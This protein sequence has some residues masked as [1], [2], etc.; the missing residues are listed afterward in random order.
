MAKVTS[1]YQ[2]KLPKAIVQE[3]NIQ[4]G[5]HLDW[6]AAGEV[7]RVIPPEARPSETKSRVRLFDQ[8]TERSRRRAKRREP[9]RARK[10]GWTREDLYTRGRAH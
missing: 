3:Y 8:A 6:V 4:P 10:R 7:I 5:D 1:N 2:V 9:P